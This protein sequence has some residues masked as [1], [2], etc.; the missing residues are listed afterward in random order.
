LTKYTDAL[1]LDVDENIFTFNENKLT[2]SNIP[3]SKGGTGATTKEQALINLGAQALLKDSSYIY[4]ED[5]TI[6]F[7]YGLFNRNLA[8]D[9]IVEIKPKNFERYLENITTSIEVA[10]FF[11]DYYGKSN[12]RIKS[13]DDFKVYELA[14][15]QE[16]KVY[17]VEKIYNYKTASADNDGLLSAADK[18]KLDKVKDYEF[19][20][21]EPES[22]RLF[23]GML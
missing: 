6:K 3:I 19:G 21:I 12:F 7:D 14:F 1:V 11:N 15:N 16:T 8:E 10:T 4:I 18:N 13:Q 9:Y 17:E 20:S 5:N 2:I 23:D 22:N